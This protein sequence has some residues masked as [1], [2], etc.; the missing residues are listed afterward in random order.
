[1]CGVEAVNEGFGCIEFRL[2]HTMYF[3]SSGRRC[4]NKVKQFIHL[5]PCQLEKL[6]CLFLH[7]CLFREAPAANQSPGLFNLLFERYGKFM[8]A[9]LGLSLKYMQLSWIKCTSAALV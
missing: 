9:S 1:M 8:R 5:G 7:V 4:R 6:Q 3:F 2:D